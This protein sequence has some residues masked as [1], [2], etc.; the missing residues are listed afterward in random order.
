MKFR[1]L[2]ISLFFSASYMLSAQEYQPLNQ[3]L[4]ALAPSNIFPAD[5]TK[6]FSFTDT[7]NGTKPATFEVN[8]NKNSPV[9]VAE[10]F[11]TA[12]SH[13]NIQAR[14]KS[15]GK[16][17]KGAVLMA[18]MSMRAVYAKQESGESNVN[19]YI[20]SKNG[21]RS[22]AI[23]LAAGPEWKSYNIPFTV[24]ADIPDGEALIGITFGALAQKVEITNIEVLNFENKTTLEKLPITRFTYL[25]REENAAWRIA[26][27]KRIE[28]IRTTPLNIQVVSA[29]GKPVKGA[30]VEAR[31]VQSDFIWGTAAKEDLLA[32]DLPNSVKYKQ[33]LKEF[34]NTAVVENGFKCL[35]W[36]SPLQPQ[37]KRAFEW[38]EKEGLRQRGH[39]LVWMGWKFNDPKVKELAL[40]D[41]A[42][43][44]AYI[45]KNIKE[46]M[47]YTKGR[48]IALDV[49]NE[50]NHEQDFLKYLPKDIAIKFYKL[51]K[52][53]DP[54]A[55][56]FMNEYA[57]LNSIESPRNIKTYLDTI[58]TMRAKGAPID[59]IGIQG[60]VGRQPRN[61]A[62]V[63]TDLDMFNST[64]LPVQITEFDVNTPDEEL[65]ADYTR[66][67]LIA[68]Y[69]HPTV[70]GFVKWGFWQNAHWK[71]DAAMFRT[72]WTA[73]LEKPVNLTT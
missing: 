65:Q 36:D 6:S 9:F 32:E 53:L 69:S 50:Y 48:V 46:K 31:L 44:E 70:S 27:L 8:S 55:Q 41:T 28:E 20:D 43:F 7:S 59:A 45:I 47:A 63:I 38:L 29:D 11:S 18:R 34:F 64:G 10:V 14:W 22:V 13:F 5:A 35:R 67:F 4:S 17:K 16:I 30:K 12:K 56:L 21:S 25:G 40:T 54:K 1:I 42:A 58:A 49:I 66:D 51:A 15:N 62:Q 26:A 33:T 23:F 73:K 37:T 19:F 60:H 71:P 52:E 3:S 68:C 57:M 39:N 72:D 24:N 2:I 61:P